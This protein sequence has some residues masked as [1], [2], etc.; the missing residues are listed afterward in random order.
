MIRQEDDHEC[1]TGDAHQCPQH[2]LP[3]AQVV[4]AVARHQIEAGGSAPAQVVQKRDHRQQ[5][6]VGI[7]CEAANRKVRQQK[8]HQKRSGV[9]QQVPAE[10][11]FL[12]PSTISS[13]V[14]VIR[15]RNTA[16]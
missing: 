6:R 8:Q 14:P 4:G 9:G 5:Q 13:A 12:L 3:C 2:L 11:G 7:R 16:A 10:A 1:E 15:W